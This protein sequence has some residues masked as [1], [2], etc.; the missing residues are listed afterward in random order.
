MPARHNYDAKIGQRVRTLR[1]RHN[2]STGSLANRLGVSETVL[3]NC[4]S[5]RT[6]FR[7]FDL[8]RVAEALGE[9][10]EVF[11]AFEEDADRPK[12]FADA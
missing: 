9:P 1:L 2:L 8:Y 3:R 4:E 10:L 12:P 6:S 5:G 7:A 11:F